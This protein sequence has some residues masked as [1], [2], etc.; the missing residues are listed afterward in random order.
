MARLGRGASASPDPTLDSA[1]SAGAVANGAGL[2]VQTDGMN[3]MP[4]IHWAR[5][6]GGHGMLSS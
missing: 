6:V 4:G 3:F 2:V 5:S 1:A